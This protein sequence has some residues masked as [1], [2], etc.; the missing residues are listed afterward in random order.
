M[1][2]PNKQ[3]CSATYTGVDVVAS[4][5]DSSNSELWS[6]ASTYALAVDCGESATALVRASK[7][8]TDPGAACAPLAPR[9]RG[10]VDAL[11]RAPPLPP[12]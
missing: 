12:S 3:P 6:N 10:Q 2:V 5:S 4:C 9:S 8:S 7:A 1:V 11:I